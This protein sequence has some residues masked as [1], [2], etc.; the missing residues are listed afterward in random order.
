MK[1]DIVTDVVPAGDPNSRKTMKVDRCRALWWLDRYAIPNGRREALLD[2]DQYDAG[3]ELR[4]AWYAQR[5]LRWD[6]K[7][8]AGQVDAR[9]DAEIGQAYLQHA[10]R[11][12]RD[13]YCNASGLSH[14]QRVV[15]VR[16]C[17]LDQA[18]RHSEHI[19]T[20]Q[21]GLS[22]LSRFWANGRPVTD[23]K[24]PKEVIENERRMLG[25]I[26]PCVV[27]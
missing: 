20:L 3:I 24:V 1:G 19:K 8:D 4:K 9:G 17:M 25:A 27:L 14:A 18:L 2:A 23:G 13:F 12:L 10:E 11:I 5:G 26:K 6:E 16:V 7:P 22:C 21:R 15:M